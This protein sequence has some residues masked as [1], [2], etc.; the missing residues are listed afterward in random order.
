MLRQPSGTTGCVPHGTRGGD[1][2]ADEVRAGSSS[3]AR[4]RAGDQAGPQR[5][6]ARR[7]LRVGASASSS[8]PS[9]RVGD[10]RGGAGGDTGATSTPVAR[11]AREGNGIAPGSGLTLP[12]VVDNVSSRPVHG[13][14][15]FPERFA[16]TTNMTVRTTRPVGDQ[17]HCQ[18]LNVHAGVDRRGE[19]A[20]PRRLMAVPGKQLGG[21]SPGK[22]NIARAPTKISFSADGGGTARYVTQLHRKAHQR[23]PT[24]TR[25]SQRVVDDD[26]HEGA[27]RHRSHGQDVRPGHRR[28]R[29]ER[30]KI[31]P[32][33]PS[34]SSH[35]ST[36]SAGSS[37]GPKPLASG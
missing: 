2:R 14:G 3:S 24:P 20:G 31:R 7:S 5:R 28:F 9:T 11:P 33:A 4:V 16:R 17:G 26:G 13:R 36:T 37:C 8:S 22:A 35:Q 32:A 1:R 10:G 29:L 12:F 18:Q 15:A 30:R 23:R 25:R 34:R 19:S 21:A 27:V 6:A